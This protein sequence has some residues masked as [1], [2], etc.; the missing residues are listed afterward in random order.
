MEMETLVF[1]GLVFVVAALLWILNRSN[2]KLAEL[3]PVPVV[4]EMIRSAV[5]TALD[6]AEAR[7]KT[8][9]TLAD[10]ELVKVIRE[11]VLKQFLAVQNAAESVDTRR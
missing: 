10:D 8:T 6:A 1:I 4:Q 7:A 5:N 2:I 9:A 11:E 3:V